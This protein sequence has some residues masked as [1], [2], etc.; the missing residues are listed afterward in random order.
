MIE[1]WRAWPTMCGGGGSQTARGTAP[2]RE[3]GG[4]GLNNP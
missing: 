2:H 3:A 4:L 1:R